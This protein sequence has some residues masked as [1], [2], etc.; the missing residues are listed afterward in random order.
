[1]LNTLITSKTRINLLLKFFLNPGTKAYLR[2]LSSEFGESTNAVRVELNRLTDAKL[3]KS[4]SLGR[5]ILYS[6]NRNHNLFRDIE[7][8]VRKYVGID[9][10]VEDL[11]KKLGNIDAAYI[12]GDYS[13]GIDSRLIDVVLVGDVDQNILKKFVVKT[14]KLIDRKIRPLILNDKEFYRL[15]DRLDINNALTIWNKNKDKFIN[16]HLN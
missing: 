9:K 13:R 11:I 16:Y 8:V 10:L 7:S 12:I 3:L 15:R 6:A 1:M 14:E 4:T 2:E 5:K